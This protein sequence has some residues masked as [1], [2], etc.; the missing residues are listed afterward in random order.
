M[1]I[2]DPI[3][4]LL[5]RLR[6][7]QKAN[8][9]ALELPDSKIKREIL[10]ILQAEGFI[11][12]YEVIPDA[13]QNRI[14]VTLR[15]GQGQG[16]RREPVIT[17][18]KRVSKPGLRVYTPANELPVVLRGLGVAILTTSRGVMTAKQARRLG[19]GGEVLAYIY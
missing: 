18:L 6:N 2:S 11:K 15:Y 7:A 12:S 13:P 4:D 16:Q 1:V 8:H 9:D 10:R 14:K 5:T 17:G 3:G 19:V